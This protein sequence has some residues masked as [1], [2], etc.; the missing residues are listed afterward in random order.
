MAASVWVN[1]AEASASDHLE[2]VQG[3]IHVGL[4]MA[5]AERTPGVLGWPW[6]ATTIGQARLG[7][8]RSGWM[9]PERTCPFAGTANTDGL[10]SPA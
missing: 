3:S 10:L 4:S 1:D 8:E 9:R 6:L 7:E 5:D 2:M